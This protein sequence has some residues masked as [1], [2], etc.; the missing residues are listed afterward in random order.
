MSTVKNMPSFFAE[1]DAAVDKVMEK[2]LYR[3]T[4]AIDELHVA[5]EERT[6]V[7]SGSAVANFQWS[8]G[9]P[10]YTFIEPIDNGDPGPTNTMALGTE[11]RRPPNAQLSLDSLMSLDIGDGTG[12]YY[13]NNNDPD[14]EDLEMGA[15]P[16]PALSRSPAGMIDVS[17]HYVYM[18]L[19]TVWK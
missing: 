14:I 18:M 8:N 1:L 4:H 2:H 12:I 15:L 11:P 9:S 10:N 3:I 13:L 17:V 19:E 5:I 7:W 16:T 6:P